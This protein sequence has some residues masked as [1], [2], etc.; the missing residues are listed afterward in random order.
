MAGGAGDVRSCVEDGRV[1]TCGGVLVYWPEGGYE[2]KDQ[3]SRRY[4]KQLA[5][6]PR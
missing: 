6:K 2:G 4:G 3:G 1:C 5:A